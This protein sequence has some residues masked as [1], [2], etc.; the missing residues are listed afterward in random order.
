MKV[1]QGAAIQKFT[2]IPNETPTTPIQAKRLQ[3]MGVKRGVPDY[4]LI[5]RHKPL[6]IEL[7]RVEG[8][9]VSGPQRSWIDALNMAG[10][11]TYVC[12]GAAEAKALV[13]NL[14]DAA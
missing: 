13:S 12:K 14:L 9:V 3:R 5:L 10:V 8:G 4:F 6:F 11:P 2:H 7:K 1:A